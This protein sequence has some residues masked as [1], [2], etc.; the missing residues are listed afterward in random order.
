[1]IRIYKYSKVEMTKNHIVPI[2]NKTRKYLI[3]FV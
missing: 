1:M 3:I 2:H